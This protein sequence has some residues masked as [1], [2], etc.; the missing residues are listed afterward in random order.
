[1]VCSYTDRYLNHKLWRFWNWPALSLWATQFEKSCSSAS[2]LY[3]FS[4]HTVSL[5]LCTFH[6]AKPEFNST[7]G[8]PNHSYATCCL[9]EF[10]YTMTFCTYVSRVLF[11]R[12]NNQAERCNP[13]Q[14]CNILFKRLVRVGTPINALI[15]Q[16][17]ISWSFSHF[18]RQEEY[19]VYRKWLGDHG[20]LESWIKWTRSIFQLPDSVC[21]VEFS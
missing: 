8:Y 16:E 6:S 5:N 3:F 12:V 11:S 14:L 1:M 13:G 19:R 2:F 4:S 21:K 17:S 9:S 20:G 18:Y 7:A 10:G 15:P